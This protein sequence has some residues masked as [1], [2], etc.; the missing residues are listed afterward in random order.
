M[1]T[2]RYGDIVR[3]K[4]LVNT[5]QGPYKF[6]LSFANV[7]SVPFEKAVTASRIV[8]IGKGLNKEVLSSVI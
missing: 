7:Q 1:T 6:D 2:G 8:I 4:A 3:A 5:V